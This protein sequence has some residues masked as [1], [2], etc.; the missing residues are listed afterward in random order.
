MSSLNLGSGPKPFKLQDRL[1]LFACDV[2]RTVQFLHTRG[3]VA[4]ALSYQI[5]DAGTSVG[6]NAE[7]A[8]G[9]SS[10][11]DFIA[12]MRISLKEAK[13]V[14]YRM[15]VCRRC[16]FLDGRFDPLLQESDEI[17]RIIGKIVHNATRNALANKLRSALTLIMGIWH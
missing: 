12:K 2:V 3:P 13:E 17:V 15:T 14:R 6:S 11:R 5:L 8:D 10:R 7:E 16:E 4:R 1:L 9:A